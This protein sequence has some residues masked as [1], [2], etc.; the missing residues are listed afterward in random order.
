MP[1]IKKMCGFTVT[2][3]EAFCQARGYVYA[4]QA[5]ELRYSSVRAETLHFT[6]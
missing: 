6:S 2:H 5:C 4:L 1:S 3:S